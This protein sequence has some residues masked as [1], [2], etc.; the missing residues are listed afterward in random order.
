MCLLLQRVV[1]VRTT[2]TGSGAAAVAVRAAGDSVWNRV[3][4]L[5]GTR[6][7]DLPDRCVGAPFV[8]PS[9]RKRGG[10]LDA[11]MIR[12]LG[13]CFLYCEHASARSL[14]HLGSVSHLAVNIACK[15]QYSLRVPGCCKW[16]CALG[17]GGRFHTQQSASPNVCVS[18]WWGRA[19]CVAPS[20]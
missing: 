18:V 19:V 10:G 9:G 7:G 8:R 16:S 5:V 6:T 20:R 1:C 17:R 2:S 13:P 14:G 3:S 15:G 11:L 4:M 12:D